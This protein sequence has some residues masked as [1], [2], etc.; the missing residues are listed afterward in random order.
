MEARQIKREGKKL[1]RRR[2]VEEKKKALEAGGDSDTATMEIQVLEIQFY[3]EQKQK[4]CPQ[5][6][7][8]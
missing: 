8:T 2:A 3:C 5:I 1:E 7:R 6:S 4:N